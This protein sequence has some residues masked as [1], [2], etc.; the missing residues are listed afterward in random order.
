MI[1]WYTKSEEAYKTSIEKDPKFFDSYFNV[2]VLY[3]NR[4][5]YEYEKCNA[6]KSDAEY[7]KCKTGAD[8]I[9]LKRSHSSRKHTN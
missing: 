8:E 1:E 4:A 9:Y 6:F 5:A 7:S 3:N 2:G